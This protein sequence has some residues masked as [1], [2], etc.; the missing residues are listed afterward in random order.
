MI[1]SASADHRPG[2][3]QQLAAAAFPPGRETADDHVR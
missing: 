3:A 1:T 2:T